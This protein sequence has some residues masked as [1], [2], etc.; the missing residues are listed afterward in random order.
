MGRL[1]EAFSMMDLSRMVINGATRPP[2]VAEH[3]R[4]VAS[5]ALS[6]SVFQRP[7]SFSFVLRLTLLI[8]PCA[9]LS[10]TSGAMACDSSF[11]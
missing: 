11:S 2:A 1:P 4:S 8:T 3:M 5:R 6:F 9:F 7:F 10:A